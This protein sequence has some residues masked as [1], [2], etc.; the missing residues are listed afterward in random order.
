MIQKVTWT[1][2]NVPTG[3]DSL[4][5]FLAQ[6]SSSGTY[7]FQVQQTYSDGSIV[8]WTGS[9]SSERPAP[10]IEAKASLGGGGTSGADDHRARPRRAR[11]HPRPRSRCSRAAAGKEAAR[12]TQ[13]GRG[14]LSSRARRVGADPAGGGVC[15]RVP[16]QDV[17]DAERDPQHPAPGRRADL[18]RGGRAA[19]RDHLGHRTPPATRRRPAAGQPL[20]G[21]SR[22]A[23]RAAARRTCPRAGT[24]STGARSR[25]TAIPSRARSRSRSA[26]TQGPRRSSRCRRSRRSRRRPSCSSRAG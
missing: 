13:R 21:E 8:D 15:A 11:R 5:Q 25:S 14:V 10:T 2:G 9:E 12:M 6:P 23:R 20:A 26:R 17:P 19:L 24:S 7:T 18:R 4:F 22:H 16:G 3:E 1:G